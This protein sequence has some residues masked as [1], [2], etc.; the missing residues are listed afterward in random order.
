MQAILGDAIARYRDGSPVCSRGA[1]NWIRENDW[2][3]K[4]SFNNVC[5]A[6]HMDPDSMRRRVLG[7]DDEVELAAA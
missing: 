5:S 3:S 6:L 1:E 7:A 4:L 2:H